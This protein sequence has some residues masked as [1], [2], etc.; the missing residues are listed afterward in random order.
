MK[1]NSAMIAEIRPIP[2]NRC[3]DNALNDEHRAPQFETDSQLVT[4][5]AQEPD[6]GPFSEWWVAV[7]Q[8]R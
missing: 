4:W 3:S 5:L 8:E 1:T 7:Q 6:E 2:K